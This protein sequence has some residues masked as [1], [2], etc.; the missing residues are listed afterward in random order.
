MLHNGFS[1]S[2]LLKQDKAITEFE[3]MDEW[4]IHGTELQK[5]ICWA[6]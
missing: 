6:Q 3:W 5:Y 2:S 4:A 1:I